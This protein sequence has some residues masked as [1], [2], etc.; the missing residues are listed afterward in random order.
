IF[1]GHGFKSY[2]RRFH[3]VLFYFPPFCL[4]VDKASGSRGGG[5]PGL[6]RA[7]GPSAR[8]IPHRIPT[9][10]THARTRR[11]PRT[12]ALGALGG[13]WGALGGSAW[14]TWRAL[15]RALGRPG[16]RAGAPASPRACRP[17]RAGGRCPAGLCACAGRGALPGG[18]ARPG[19]LRAGGPSA[20]EIP[21]RIP[22][23]TTHA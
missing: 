12:R 1:G 23:Q 10:T 15:G 6:L 18:P 7:G 20:R 3:Y 22:T 4:G 14:S 2:W 8:E 9:Q 21:H 19:L 16:A 17:A 13:A 5:A 11:A